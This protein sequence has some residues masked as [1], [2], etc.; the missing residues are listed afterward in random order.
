M[1]IDLLRYVPPGVRLQSELRLFAGGMIAS[2]LYSIGFLLRYCSAYSALQLHVLPS[3]RTAAETIM[4]D[5]YL[6]LGSALYGFFIMALCMSSFIVY[7]YASHFQGSKSIYLMRR[8]PS[9][10]ELHRRCWTLPLL[11]ILLFLLSAA[12]LLVVYYG[13]YMAFTPTECLT[14]DQW[15]KIWSVLP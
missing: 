6:L 8:L 12:L 10:A 14:P 7:H 13:I 3:L 11:F 2:C 1:K 15:Q 9:R 4:P 5:F